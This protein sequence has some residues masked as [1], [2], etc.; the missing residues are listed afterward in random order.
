MRS[1]KEW[2]RKGK[3]VVDWDTDDKVIA[4]AAPSREDL[5]R[6]LHAEGMS[7]IPEDWGWG[8]STG[9]SSP[10]NRDRSPALLCHGDTCGACG[11]EG[12]ASVVTIELEAD[13]YE[14]A[15]KRLCDSCDAERIDVYRFHH[16]E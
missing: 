10:W 5:K 1:W 4:I 11:R 14:V 13:N 2:P 3:T 15:V 9:D 12:L 16:Y 8:S 7:P 6:S